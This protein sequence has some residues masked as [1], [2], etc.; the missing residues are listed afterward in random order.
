MPEHVVVPPLS[1]GLELDPELC[2]TALASIDA[3]IANAIAS[4]HA[5]R[6]AVAVRLAKIGQVLA[7]ET[8]R[9]R[10]A[11]FAGRGRPRYGALVNPGFGDDDL[12]LPADENAEGG[13]EVAD[14]TS[15]Q[16]ETMMMLEGLSGKQGD[17][18]RAKELSELYELR[19]RLR[20]SVLEEDKAALPNIEERIRV[21]LVEYLPAKPKEDASCS[22]SSPASTETSPSS[23]KETPSAS[24]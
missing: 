17:Q 20:S 21:L 9:P 24:A 22:G 5:Q 15:M 14:H 7:R 4:G 3:L 8:G 1:T 23:P 2:K 18:A 13:F 19:D 10:V 16:R 11:Q 6:F 12:G